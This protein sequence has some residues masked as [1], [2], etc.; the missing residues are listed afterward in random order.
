[1]RRVV[2]RTEQLDVIDFLPVRSGDA[3][4]AECLPDAP[5][6]VGEP[7][8]IGKVQHLPVLT[9]EE[10]PVAAPGHVAD[11][12]ADSIDCDGDRCGVAIA[13]HVLDGNAVAAGP[14]ERDDADGGLEAVRAGL[15][16]AEVGERDR[17]ADGAMPAHAE[18]A[19]VIE[20]DDTG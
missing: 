12:L 2:R 11:D 13:R 5:G 1:S 6:E 3:A 16:A 10:E 15:N 19:N 9:D 7:L 8:D 4:T 14:V 18:I 17:N 20:V